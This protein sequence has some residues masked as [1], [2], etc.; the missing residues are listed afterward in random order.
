MLKKG[1]KRKTPIRK[2]TLIVKALHMVPDVALSPHDIALHD[3]ARIA[4]RKYQNYHL[5]P[6]DRRPIVVILQFLK[7]LR[8]N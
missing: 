4:S 2:I 1:Y 5:K 8:G 6:H 7:L 3:I